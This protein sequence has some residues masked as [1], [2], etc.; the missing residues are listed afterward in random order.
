MSLIV[1]SQ[2]KFQLSSNQ[3]GTVPID[4]V[5]LVLFPTLLPDEIDV[6][7]TVVESRAD[8]E[9]HKNKAS[10]IA[11]FSKEIVEENQNLQTGEDT[12]TTKTVW[13]PINRGR[14]FDEDLSAN[15]QTIEKAHQ[16]LKTE[17]ESLGAKVTIQLD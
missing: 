6:K 17:L 10:I 5:T 11:F 1:E 16:L 4:E 15:E 13:E 7:M 12:S 14:K 3:I 2:G 9:T 8:Y